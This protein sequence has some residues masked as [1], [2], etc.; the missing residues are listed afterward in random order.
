MGLTM[1]KI[2]NLPS[3]TDYYAKATE[4]SPSDVGYLLLAQSL[5]KIGQHEQAQAALTEAAKISAN[6]DVARQT[7]QATLQ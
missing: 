3:A 5:E 1:Q 7:V 6:F 2:G 4:V